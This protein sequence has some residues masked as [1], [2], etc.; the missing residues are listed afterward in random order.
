MKIITKFKI[1]KICVKTVKKKP[2]P[3]EKKQVIKKFQKQPCNWS[4][5]GKVNTQ[6]RE[7]GEMI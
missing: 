7:K 6:K 5:R 1:K 2:I 4:T 3:A